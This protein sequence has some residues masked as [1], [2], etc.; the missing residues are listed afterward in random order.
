M[1]QWYWRYVDQ[2]KSGKQEGKQFIQILCNFSQYLFN[3][4]NPNHL[5]HKHR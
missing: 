2:V 4:T 5:R 1:S 3:H